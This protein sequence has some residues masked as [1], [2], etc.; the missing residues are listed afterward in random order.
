MRGPEHEEVDEAGPG[1]IV[2]VAKLKD[3]HTGDVLGAEKGAPQ[4]APIPIPQG[5]I[6][7]AISAKSKGDED[8][9]YAALGRLVR[10]IRPCSWVVKPPPG[11]SCSPG[12][13][14]LHV[15]IT[16]QKLQRL[17]GVD[18]ELKTPKVPYRETIKKQGR[19]RRG[20]AQEADRRQ[21]NVRS[22]LPHAGASPDAAS[23]IEFVDEIKSAA[24]FRAV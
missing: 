10:R 12:M 24:R 4:I 17:F 8:K 16:V 7:Y 21:G 11:S 1:D 22:L 20:Q 23:G 13:G 15:R 14:E 6:S 2:A 18:V 9:V 3:T 5:V 19:E